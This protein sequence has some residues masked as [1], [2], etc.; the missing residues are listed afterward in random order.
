MPIE[1]IKIKQ[2]NTT[3]NVL[4]IKDDPQNWRLWRAFTRIFARSNDLGLK[5]YS[6]LLEKKTKMPAREIAQKVRAP[7]YS[8]DKVLRDLHEIGLISHERTKIRPTHR[9]SIDYWRVEIPVIGM[10]RLIPEHYFE[11]GYPE[12][13]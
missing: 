3:Q 7:R 2:F 11:N 10:L 6:V 4:I 9:R 8:V 1:E 5:V 12:T 13:N